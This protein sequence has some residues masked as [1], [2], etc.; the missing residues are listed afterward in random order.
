MPNVYDAFAAHFTV[1]AGKTKS[2]DHKK[3]LLLLA[4]QWRSLGRGL[5]GPALPDREGHDRLTPERTLLVPKP[6]RGP[7]ARADGLGK[8]I[9][10]RGDRSPQHLRRHPVR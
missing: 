9:D 1:L 10:G 7:W 3:R 6:R 8:N 2:S 4:E 5:D